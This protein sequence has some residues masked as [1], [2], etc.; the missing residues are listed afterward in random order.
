MELKYICIYFSQSLSGCLR[1]ICSNIHFRYCSV[2]C[3]SFRS[4][5]RACMRILQAHKR[6]RANWLQSW[7]I[8]ETFTADSTQTIVP[9]W[10]GVGDKILLLFSKRLIHKWGEKGEKVERSLFLS[11]VF[12]LDYNTFLE[13]LYVWS[14]AEHFKE[15]IT[16]QDWNR[17]TCTC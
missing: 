1:A 4:Y 13:G 5:F 12:W 17:L 10:G 2:S 14:N 6:V 16:K 7:L 8:E 3:V 11:L 15:H 9:R